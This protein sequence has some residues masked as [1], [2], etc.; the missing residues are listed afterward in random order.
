MSDMNP[1]DFSTDE[2]ISFLNSRKVTPDFVSRAKRDPRPAVR[3][4]AV[5]AERRVRKEIARLERLQSLER[6]LRAG[7]ALQIA[8]VDESGRGPL[9]GPVVASAVIFPPDLFI[10]GV[11]DCKK[12]TPERR[13]E[14]FDAVNEMAISVGTA[15]VESSEIDS[16]NILRASLK[17]MRQAVADLRVRPDVAIVDGR[18]CPGCGVREIPVVKGDSISLSVAA[19]SIIAKV[20]R[21]RIMETSTRHATDS[22]ALSCDCRNTNASSSC[23]TTSRTNPARQSAK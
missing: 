11:D 9:A 15:V 18:D 13:S 1:F 12:L 3:A 14:L 6:K 10:P 5:K 7:G 23:C 4:T 2:A 17:A 19:A 20:T 22:C 8:G 16:I 21:D